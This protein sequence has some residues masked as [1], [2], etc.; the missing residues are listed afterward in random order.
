MIKY[1]LRCTNGHSF[2]HWFQNSAACAQELEDKVLSCPEC[3]DKDL[4]KAIMAPS[5]STTSPATPPPPCGK[6]SACSGGCPA[7]QDYD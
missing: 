3:G 1:R 6:A 2:D 4:Q 5:V 7:M